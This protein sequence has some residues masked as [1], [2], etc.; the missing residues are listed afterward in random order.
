MVSPSALFANV[1]A[2]NCLGFRAGRTL[3]VDRV[4]DFLEFR[5]ADVA[6]LSGV[7]LASVRYDQKMP[8]ELRDRLLQI[9]NICELVAQ[10]FGGDVVKTGIWFRTG[11]PLLGN[12][13]PRDMIRF[14]R[15][16]KLRRFV[17][18]AMHENQSGVT[19]E[20]A[21]TSNVP[22]LIASRR[23]AIAQLCQR[24][25][26]RQLALFGSVLRPDFNPSSSD[27]DVVVEFGP[28]PGGSAAR[29]Y[30]DFKRDLETLL[31]HAVD[32][33]EL[34]AMEDSRLKRIIERTQVPIY[35][36]AA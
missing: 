4:V 9:A 35:A 29:Q 5:K 25:G 19:S 13:S 23:D 6:K 18:Q 8:K 32:L 14:G 1:A 22:A 28:P 34:G 3:R 16:E 12:L 30:F 33:V 36:A 17:M 7:A 20:T 15:Y 10:H 26:V 2:L 21:T 27:V 24:C 11:N 31:G